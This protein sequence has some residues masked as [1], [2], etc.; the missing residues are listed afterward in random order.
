M[1]ELYNAFKNVI[2]K[3]GYDLTALLKKIDLYNIEGKITDDERTELYA[4]ARGGAKP[5]DS[6]DILAKLTELEQRVKALEGKG[7]EETVAEYV[8]G[9]WYYAGDK[10]TFEGVAYVCTAPEGTVC[11][12][13]PKEYPA[14]WG[15]V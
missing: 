11:V 10:C 7:T 4:I 1:N 13:S 8:A 12:W 15:E 2:S 9:K 3:G 6:V 5:S 14:Y